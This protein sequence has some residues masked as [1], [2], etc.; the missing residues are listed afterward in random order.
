[1][2]ELS[3]TQSLVDA[4]LERTG[5]RTVTGVNLRIGPLSGVLPDAMRFCFDIVSA[6]TSLAG[7]QLKIDEPQGLARCRSCGT[8][9][10]LADLILLCP[11]GSA[12]V[13]VLSGRELMV[14]SVE[15]A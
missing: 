5:E 11:C 15:V 3:I 8:E 4:V 13:E 2:H 9:F 14:M 6:G 7:A 1:M 10:E 12:D